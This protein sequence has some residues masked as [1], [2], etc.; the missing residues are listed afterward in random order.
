HLRRE[1]GE[2]GP[3]QLGGDLPD[4]GELLGLLVGARDD[5][6]ERVAALDQVRVLG[7]LRAL[8]D[9][10]AELVRL[11]PGVEQRQDRR[12]RGADRGACPVLIAQQRLDR[13]GT[14]LGTSTASVLAL[15]DS[16][17]DRKSTRLNSSHS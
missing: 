10:A 12:G 1:P 9:L 14:S 17:P 15:L 11:R 6:G 4:G 7:L 16:W 3:L 13:A 8:A 5:A 2:H